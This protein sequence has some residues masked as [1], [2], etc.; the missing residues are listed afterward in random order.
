MKLNY[1]IYSL[2]AGVVLF[3]SACSPDEYDLGA[4]D[5]AAEDLVEGTAYTVT[6]DSQNPNI[7]YLESKL[8]DSYTVLWEHPQGRS[9]EK[10]VALE[11]PFDGTYTVKFGVETRGGIVYGEPTT[12]TIDDFCADFIQDNMWALVSGGVGNSKTWVLDLDAEGFSRHFVGPIYFFTLGYCWDN[13][14]SA[15][16]K[17]YL[18]SKDWDPKQAIVPNVDEK[19]AATWFWTAD[20]PGNS[21]VCDKADFGTMTFDLMGGANI[22]TD[23]ES[24]GLGKLQGTYMLNTNNHTL[25]FTDAWPVRD[26]GRDGHYK[27]REFKILYLSEDFM[28]L[29]IEVDNDGSLICYNYISKDYADNWAPKVDENAVPELPDGWQDEVSQIKNQTIVWKL[30]ADVPFDWC[31]LYGKRKNGFSK[32]EDYPAWCTP[33]QKVSDVTLT[34]DSKR[35]AYKLELPDGSSVEGTYTLS[36]D[37]IYTFSNG[38]ASYLVGSDWIYFGAD[39]DNELR[40]M[41]Y[42]V[43]S[44]GVVSDMWLGAKQK[45]ANGKLYQYLAYHF[46]PQLDATQ[47]SVYDAS[48]HIFDTSSWETLESPVIAVSGESSY[49]A[50]IQGDLSSINHTG[51]YGWYIDILG[52]LGEHPNVTFAVTSIKA[53]DVD[54]S[55]DSSLIDTAAQE[56]NADTGKTESRIMLKNAW[57]TGLEIPA[58]TTSLSVTFTVAFND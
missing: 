5:I 50:T 54:V 28:Q 8:K 43:P 36:A 35:G 14:H 44:T 21:W 24:Y 15:D 31:D 34:I 45:D 6:H 38:L 16:G 41:S 26:S 19:G 40:L 20:W 42:V 47:A 22:V 29:G 32:A 53:D 12:F 57:G 30:S 1:Y 52:I 56:N 37:G 55:F 49:T 7:V 33:A 46:E 11:I 23:Q 27:S 39:E 48:M 13:L 25:T 4:K 51:V 9:Q 3:L 58:F 18:D 2:I 10:K 17:N